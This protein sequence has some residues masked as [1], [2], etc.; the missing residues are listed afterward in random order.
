MPERGRLDV[1]E[2]VTNQILSRLEK[3]VI[4]WHSPSIARV[5]YPRNF[6]TK[7]TYSGINVFL[8]GVQEFQSPH[9]LTFRQAL[10]LGGNVKKGEKGFHIIKVGS[11]K[12]EG[13]NEE[14]KPEERKFLRLYTVFNACQIEGIVFP[15]PP[16]CEAFTETEQTDNA[17]KIVEA[18]P[19]RPVIHEGC[20]TYPHYVPDDDIIEMP[21]RES[22]RSEWLFYKTLFHELAH[23]T[24]HEKRLNRPS[25]TENRGHNAVGE[26][27]KTY[28]LEELVA[29]MTA[30]FVGAAAG[31]VEQGFEHSAAYLQGWLS[32]LKVKD[33][34]TWLVKAASEA[35]K[36]ADFILGR[37]RS[38]EA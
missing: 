35:Q 25:L 33:N 1:Y 2:V 6:L 5:G 14:E 15:E 22:F 32:V 4:P 10:E 16:K 21:T 17:R 18:M 8:L 13:A 7:I 37:K 24:G 9:F 36:A 38:E 30:T 26:D 29:E 11:W 23:A 31:M 20:K 19:Q 27:R 28:C 12:K 34:R 3:G